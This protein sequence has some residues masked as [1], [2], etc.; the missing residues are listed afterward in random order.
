MLTGRNVMYWLI[1]MRCIG[2]FW[3]YFNVKKVAVP[4]F[5]ALPWVLVKVVLVFTRTLTCKEIEQYGIICCW[6]ASDYMFMCF[7]HFFMKTTAIW[8]IAL[9]LFEKVWSLFLKHSVWYLLLVLNR[10]FLY[11]S[12]ILC[13]ILVHK[14]SVWYS[15]CSQ[16]IQFFQEV[17]IC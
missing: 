8:S 9:M 14:I 2:N 15:K 4:Y 13:I 3:C 16:S 12:V 5:S 10:T 7:N 6:I 1:E 17:Q 11:T